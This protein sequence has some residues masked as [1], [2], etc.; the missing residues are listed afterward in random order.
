MKL[1]NAFVV[2]VVLLG[3]GGCQS[4]TRPGVVIDPAGPRNASQPLLGL[5]VPN[6]LQADS[7]DP[8]DVFEAAYTCSVP[9]N[10]SPSQASGSSDADAQKDAG[11]STDNNNF[12]LKAAE[13]CADPGPVD[14]KIFLN[15]GFAYGE[16]L[17]DRYFNT[18]ANRNQDLNFGIESFSLLGGFTAAVMGITEASAKSIALTAAGFTSWIAALESYQEHY[19]FGP[20]VS[21]VRELIM[22]GMKEYRREVRDLPAYDDL[23]HFRALEF[24]REHQAICQVDYIQAKVDEAV[25]NQKIVFRRD[26]RDALTNR[27]VVATTR[28]RMAEVLGQGHVTM[29]QMETLFLLSELSPTDQ[30]VLKQIQ[31][32]LGPVADEILV[33]NAGTI[34]FKTDGK[35]GE[36]GVVISQMSTEAFAALRRAAAGRLEAVEEYIKNNPP[37]AGGAAIPMAAEAVIEANRPQESPSL[38]S[39]IEEIGDRSGESGGLD[40]A[41]VPKPN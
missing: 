33:D 3:I 14:H 34:Q 36:V 10:G 38:E 23:N 20:R 37:A 25:S 6:I 7:V 26:A 39:A 18:I 28:N 15:A 22:S 29:A 40:P 8:Y 1:T 41:L 9:L 19:H 27:V 31:A 16:L 17:C 13:D 4:P 12:G 2:G 30:Q 32:Q 5:G 11:A 24:I 21:T 35:I